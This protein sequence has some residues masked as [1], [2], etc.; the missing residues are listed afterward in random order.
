MRTRRKREFA[1]LHNQADNEIW[2]IEKL[3]KDAG[4]KISDSDKA[5]VNAAI[6]KVRAGPQGN[7]QGRRRAGP[8]QPAECGPRPGPAH[9]AQRRRC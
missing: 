2:A 9:S 5:P 6:E 1:D 7:G 4:D 3:M 8:Q